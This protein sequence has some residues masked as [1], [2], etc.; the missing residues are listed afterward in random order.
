MKTRFGSNNIISLIVMLLLMAILNAEIAKAGELK[1]LPVTL[2]GWQ[3][4]ETETLQNAINQPQL[5]FDTTANTKWRPYASFGKVFKA[6]PKKAFWLRVLLPDKE[7]SNPNILYEVEGRID[8]L[9]VGDQPVYQCGNQGCTGGGELTRAKIISLPYDHKNKLL[10]VRIVPEKKGRIILNPLKLGSQ[11]DFYSLVI[12]KIL[13]DFTIGCILI[14]AGLIFLMLFLW[15]ITKQLFFAFSLFVISL[16]MVLIANPLVIL[17][18]EFSK[19]EQTIF[20]FSF[21]IWPPCFFALYE[22]IFRSRHQWVIR[23]LWQVQLFYSVGVFVLILFDVVELVDTANPLFLII[24][25]NI[26]F[27]MGFHIKYHWNESHIANIFFFGTGVYI[28]LGLNQLLMH[29]GWYFWYVQQGSFGPLVLVISLG[30]MVER[31]FAETRKNLHTANIAKD[32]LVKEL[33][34]LNESL[35]TIVKERTT[36]LR[37]ALIEVKAA[38]K[39]TLDSIQYAKRIQ[40]SLL[41]SLKEVK[42]HLPESFII[43]LPRDIVAGDVYFTSFFESGSI[44]AVIDCTGHGVPG[45]FMTML[46]SSGLNRIINDEKILDPAEILQR[47]SFFVKM[48]LHQDTDDAPS[49]DG[50]DIAICRVNSVYRTLTYAGSRFPL[51]Y[52]HQNK[53]HTVKGDRQSI[54]YKKSDLDFRFTNH[55]IAIKKGMSFYLYSDGIIDQLGGE[56]RH[57]F[58]TRRFNHLLRETSQEPFEKQQNR[59]IQA[60]E[61]YKGRNETQ[62]DVTVIGFRIGIPQ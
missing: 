9:Y 58:G 17:Y 27:L 10:L 26:F 14:L 1:I 53:I 30:L 43:W 20:L 24:T 54:G 39:K 49:D 6:N 32:K 59:I 23:R 19:W 50:M 7:I 38:N 45:A 55:K 46:A 47:L 36:N 2:K 31:H 41:P 28:L 15:N 5:F 25:V 57:S 52:I 11:L 3:Y 48:S 51:T 62:D 8:L 29:L 42:K 21:N 61:A 33:K 12:K 4:L 35:E 40:R 60:F 56:K 44:L 22:Q 16:G 37:E 13:P 34:D 18:P